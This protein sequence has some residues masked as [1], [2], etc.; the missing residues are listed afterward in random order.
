MAKK[1][2][3][4][5]IVLIV[6]AFASWLIFGI[7]HHPVAVL[8]VIDSSGKPIVGAVI[9]PDGLRPKENGGHYMWTD[10]GPVKPVPVK[11]DAKGIAR[12]A[13][14]HYVIERLET[15]EIS[16]RVDHPD[17]CPERP[18]RTVAA[19][20][21]A[22]AKLLDR[23]K[24]I[25]AVVTRHVVTHPDP[26][27]L[28]RG[29][30]LKV[31]GYIDSKENHITSLHPQTSSRMVHGQKEWLATP[32]GFLITRRI[33]EGSNAVRLVY[34]PTNGLP[35]FSEV[36]P[37]DAS[38]GKTNEF[39]LALKPGLRLNGCLADSVPRPVT[40]GRVQIQIFSDI[41]NTTHDY[42]TWASWRPINP[43]GTFTFE[44]LPPGHGET[45]ALC[46]GF[47][48]TNGP[49][50][51]RAISVPQPFELSDHEKQIVI[52]MQPTAT[53]NITVH[54]DLGHPLPNAEVVFWPNVIW[55]NYGS[56]VFM[57]RL[58]KSEDLLLQTEINWVQLAKETP[59]LF[60]GLTGKSGVLVVSNLPPFDQPFNVGSTN[61]EMPVVTDSAGD[62]E[63][64]VQV[65]LAPG[66]TTSATVK[67]QKIGTEFI[68]HRQ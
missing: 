25:L 29:G 60:Q 55:N 50:K 43:D 4:L 67:M 12:V 1:L 61:Y 19:S 22:N 33:A 23:A 26:V 44:S 68:H 47:I 45:V 31:A 34:L 35:W 6:A 42:L 7:P 24:F 51:R 28:K 65:E 11:T 32:D 10:D 37:F 21:P 62:G 16:F 64:T 59:R 3:I 20:P 41:I 30:I 58:Y 49:S 13:Y 2:K 40:N 5:L 57:D 9:T 27:V 52:G 8:T 36:Q 38:A 17:F 48:S 15:G 63:R 14:P 56:T 53:C 66:Q 18:F 46:D 39:L 54:D